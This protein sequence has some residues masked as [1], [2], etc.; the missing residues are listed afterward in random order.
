[1]VAVDKHTKESRSMECPIE[2][3]AAVT[4]H[5][6]TELDF[7]T[8]AIYVGG[9][10]D[11]KVTTIGGSEVTFSGVPA[12]TLLPVRAKIIWNTGTTA[13]LLTACW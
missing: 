3:A 9:T 1:M 6:T 13:T 2:F 12:G 7:V 4:P 10:G 5:N 8:R 11:L